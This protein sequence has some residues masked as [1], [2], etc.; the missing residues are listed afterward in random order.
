MAIARAA[1][2]LANR[3]RK[4]S[5]RWLQ[6]RVAKPDRSGIPYPVE[7]QFSRWIADAGATEV[8]EETRRLK[9]ELEAERREAR[10][11][12]GVGKNEFVEDWF[13]GP[14]VCRGEKEE[15]TGRGVVFLSPEPEE[16]EHVDGLDFV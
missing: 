9:A 7:E 14:P 3:N 1:G 4:Q 10:R 6:H 8:W 13:N 12:A 2:E 5:Q 11:V 15:V 16:V